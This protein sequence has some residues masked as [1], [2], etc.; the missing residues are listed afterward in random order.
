MAKIFEWHWHRF[1]APGLPVTMPA[2][3][4]IKHFRWRGIY[5]VQIGPW[6]IGAV[7]GQPGEPYVEPQSSDPT[8][9]AGE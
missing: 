4:R 2:L 1:D 5:G 9:T 6:F 7:K 8:P 3:S